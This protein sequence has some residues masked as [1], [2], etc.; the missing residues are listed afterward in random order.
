MENVNSAELTCRAETAPVTEAQP[1]T[2][3]GLLCSPGCGTHMAPRPHRGMAV[4]EMVLYF[5]WGTL[6]SGEAAAVWL[7]QREG[8][9]RGSPNQM[10][11]MLNY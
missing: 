11:W 4:A 6:G 8:K 5:R 7:R 2:G 3:Q 9:E 10:A 1:S